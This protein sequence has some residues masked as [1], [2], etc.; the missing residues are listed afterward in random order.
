M[1]FANQKHEQ[2]MQPPSKHKDQVLEASSQ[3]RAQDTN[4]VDEEKTHADSVGRVGARGSEVPSP[5]NSSES[6]PDLGPAA[7]TVTGPM[8][9][10]APEP[11]ITRDEFLPLQRELP[12]EFRI[13]MKLTL[14]KAI[15][16]L[17][18]NDL[19]IIGFITMKT[20]LFADMVHFGQSD[21]FKGMS[22][23]F[24]TIF[25]D[26]KEEVAESTPE[27]Y[28]SLHEHLSCNLAEVVLTEVEEQ[29]QTSKE[30]ISRERNDSTDQSA[31]V[32]RTEIAEQCQTNEDEISRERTGSTGKFEE[33]DRLV[34]WIRKLEKIYP[35]DN[36]LSKSPVSPL[37]EN[38][39]WDLYWEVQNFAFD[40][41]PDEDE[42]EDELLHVWDG[43][44]FPESNGSV[45]NSGE[46]VE[47]AT[48]QV[49]ILEDGRNLE[50][51]LES[52]KL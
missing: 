7:G 3:L 5:M 28:I 4:P 48:P 43:Y 20:R 21:Y 8:P 1:L 44:F 29:G 16:A 12:S 26:F 34:E 24:R 37:Y 50:D 49:E 41:V 11:S 22:E 42:C 45:G 19:E 51:A 38:A 30:E 35:T 14:V 25:S 46:V 15:K 32:V 39:L 33:V 2:D 9:G 10:P 17:D 27:G 23:D 40:H 36:L 52:V 47:V 13:L 18:N 31:E 6:G